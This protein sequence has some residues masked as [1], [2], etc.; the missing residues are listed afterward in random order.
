MSSEISASIASMSWTI[1][2]F[3]ESV[4]DASDV[5]GHEAHT[6]RWAALLASGYARRMK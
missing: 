6:A 3:V 1:C 4:N 2:G 5:V